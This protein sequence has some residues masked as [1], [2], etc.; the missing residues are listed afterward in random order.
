MCGNSRTSA[1][2][3]H[4]AK[5]KNMSLTEAKTNLLLKEVKWNFEKFLV[6]RQ[7]QVVE[8][9]SSPTKP[10]SDSITQKIESVL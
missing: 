5:L 10:S 4:K 2:A 3:M 8:R 6:D 1:D 7:G 9:W